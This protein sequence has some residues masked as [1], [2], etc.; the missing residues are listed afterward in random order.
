MEVEVFYLEPLLHQMLARR[1][2]YY[3]FFLTSVH[4]YG[5]FPFDWLTILAF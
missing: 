3:F 2:N 4:Y 1:L 5:R